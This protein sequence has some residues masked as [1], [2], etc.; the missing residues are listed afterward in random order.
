MNITILEKYWGN[1]FA[2]L[3]WTR[4]DILPCFSVSSIRH[5]YLIRFGLLFCTFQLTLWTKDM[6]EYLKNSKR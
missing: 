5:A 3:S 6:R 1:L 2:E 4:I